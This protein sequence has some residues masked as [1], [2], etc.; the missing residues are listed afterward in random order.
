ML[1]FLISLTLNP[2]VQEVAKRGPLCM[3]RCLVPQHTLFKTQLEF[4]FLDIKS[5]SQ[6]NL[7]PDSDPVHRTCS[8]KTC[9]VKKRMSG[10]REN[11][12]YV[13]KIIQNLF[14]WFGRQ[15]APLT[16]RITL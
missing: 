5:D 2:I 15:L 9:F 3:R 4:C 16:L 14:C 6:S 8:G 1:S 7:T 13:H 12:I 10:S 11:Q